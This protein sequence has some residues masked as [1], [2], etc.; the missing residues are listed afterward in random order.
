VAFG[1]CPNFPKFGGEDALKHVFE[2][3]RVFADHVNVDELIESAVR[4]MNESSVVPLSVAS[5]DP[6]SKLPKVVGDIPVRTR[7][8]IEK[9]AIDAGAA[10]S[11]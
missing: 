1:F 4:V 9:A 7:K 2:Y 8:E 3:I 5:Q 11:A 10:P 6:P